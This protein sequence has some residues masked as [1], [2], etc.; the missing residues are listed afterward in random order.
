[1]EMENIRVMLVRTHTSVQGV[2]CY[3][4]RAIPGGLLAPECE[5]L[6]VDD[7]AAAHHHHHGPGPGQPSQH[8]GQVPAVQ[9]GQHRAAGDLKH[10]AFVSKVLEMNPIHDYYD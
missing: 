5:Q 7:V 6:R 10:H 9:G 1:M 3:M 4:L 2:P 8:G